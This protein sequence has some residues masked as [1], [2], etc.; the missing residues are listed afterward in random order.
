MHAISSYRGNSPT[1]TQTNKHTHTH[2]DR[3]DYNPLR[4]LARS[5]NIVVGAELVKQS[6][7]RRTNGAEPTCQ[8]QRR[9]L[10][11]L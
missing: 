5:V 6:Q 11:V 8:Q 7:R 9:L 3:G 2:T 10:L 1:N 4:T